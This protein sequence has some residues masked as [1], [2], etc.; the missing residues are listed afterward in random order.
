LAPTGNVFIPLEWT[1]L[2]VILLR[3]QWWGRLENGEKR[4]KIIIEI[5]LQL[6]LLCI[7]VANQNVK[8]LG[9]LQMG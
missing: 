8:Y 7:D 2:G 6:S 1:R 4:N 3:A 9:Y 5:T